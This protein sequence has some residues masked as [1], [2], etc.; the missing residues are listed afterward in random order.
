MKYG[1]RHIKD[2]IY[3]ANDGIITTFAIV[4]GVAGAELAPSII[5]LLGLAGLLADGFS[6]A[7]SNYLG[8]K[9]ERDVIR[10]EFDRKRDDVLEAPMEEKSEMTAL[11]MEQ[12][13][14]N[15]DAESLS[16]LMLKNK[17]FFV[18]LMMHEEFETT[19]HKKTSLGSGATTTFFSFVVAGLIPIVPFL[20]LSGDSNIFAYSVIFTALALFLIGSLRSLVTKNSW[21]FSGAEMLVV[22]GIA[23]SIA[24]AVGAYLKTVI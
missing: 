17:N 1:G 10:K 7:A 12:G 16:K 23:A 15:Q 4:A 5:V 11:L 2:I 14:D 22:G 18:D 3:G 13:Y 19:T 24:Y 6:M 8:S 20:F 21:I 9:S